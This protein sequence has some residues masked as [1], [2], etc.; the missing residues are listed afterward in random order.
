[1]PD[2][3]DATIEQIYTELRRR[4]CAVVIV[5]PSALEDA[6]LHP[7]DVEEAA[8]RIIDELIERQHERFENE[9]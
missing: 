8:W 6:A 2:L 5:N 3:A 9:E 1:M 7:Y 4:K